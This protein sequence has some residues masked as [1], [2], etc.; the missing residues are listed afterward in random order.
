MFDYQIS[1]QPHFDNACRT[2]ALRHNLAQ[3]A[4]K[5]G[6][7]KQTLRNKLNPEQ[8]HQLTW[9]DIAVLTDAT[10]DATLV[11][12]WLAQMNCLPSVP[13]NEMSSEK[14]STY[15]M[16]A[17]AAVG[18]VAAETVSDERM[19]LSRKS[20]F[21]DSINSGIRCLSLA[22]MAVHARIQCNPAMAS[23]V[24]AVSGIGASIGL[25]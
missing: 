14:L 8:V 22:A 18:Q 13:T 25:S 11:D 1:K 3:L 19:T 9:L 15:V 12:G 10:E 24:D 16:K 23:T 4:D 5:A 2:F 6:M 20:A 21:V 7:N 17:T